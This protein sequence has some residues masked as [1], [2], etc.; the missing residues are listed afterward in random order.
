MK[1]NFLSLHILL[2]LIFSQV[3]SYSQDSLQTHKYVNFYL[4]CFACDFDFV[5][6]ELPF[7][8][9]VRDAGVADVHILVTVSHTGSGAH[10]YFMNFIG[11]N[12]F[13]G[14]DSE[15]EL[16]TDPTYTEDDSRKG[17]LKIIKVG[18]LP[19][20]SKTDLFSKLDIS[21]NGQEDSK[22]RDQVIDRWNK[23][24]FRISSG[25][26]LQKEESQNEFSVRTEARIEKITENWKTRMSASYNLNREN[27]FD[28][29]EKISNN[30]DASSIHADFIKSLSTKWSAGV[31]ADY[32]SSSFLNTDNEIMVAAGIEYNIFPWDECNRRVFTVGYQIG[33]G[34]WDYR[35]ETIYDKFSETHPFEALAINLEIIQP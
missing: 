17:L 16:T 7:V 19:Y 23:W 21:L 31:F 29:G 34:Y 20:I 3:N 15:Y 1:K 22:A 11:M 28:D 10:K 8:S 14:M 35:E 30:Q 26:E 2:I 4:D 12:S 5:R 27:Y 9:F 32:S 6:Q 13:K 33:V 24:I 18:I 25:G